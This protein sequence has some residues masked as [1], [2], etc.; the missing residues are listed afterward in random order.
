MNDI[1]RIAE[2]MIGWAPGTQL[3]DHNV[4]LSVCDWC[5]GDES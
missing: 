4:P 3:C 2:P 1:K 5:D